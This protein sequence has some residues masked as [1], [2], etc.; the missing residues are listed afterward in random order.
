M[1]HFI[2]LVLLLIPIM[3]QADWWKVR[4]DSTVLL[5]FLYDEPTSTDYKLKNVE[6]WCSTDKTIY[7]KVTTVPASSPTGGKTMSD[8]AAVAI[9]KETKKTVSC[10]AIAVYDGGVRAVKSPMVSAI[11][12]RI[13]PVANPVKNLKLLTGTKQ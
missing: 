1:K 6:L 9:A 2:F 4:D 7:K 13:T 10:Y 8:F 11:I 3:A 5:P 12:N